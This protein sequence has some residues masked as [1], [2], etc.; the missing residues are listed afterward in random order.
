[1]IRAQIEADT[2]YPKEVTLRTV[3]DW[4]K[5]QLGHDSLT[6][7]ETEYIDSRWMGLITQ[8]A[9]KEEVPVGWL[10]WAVFELAQ[11]ELRL[12]QTAI[13]EGTEALRVGS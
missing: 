2:A 13:S 9:E 8:L 6:P 12:V 10:S 7:A 1:M 3:T 11:H 4:Y 5:T